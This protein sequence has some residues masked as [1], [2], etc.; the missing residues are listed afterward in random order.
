[1]RKPYVRPSVVE[2]GE[3]SMLTAQGKERGP[4]KEVFAGSTTAALLDC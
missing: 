4:R 3:A 2:L 1:M